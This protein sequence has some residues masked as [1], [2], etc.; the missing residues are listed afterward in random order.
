NH[1]TFDITHPYYMQLKAVHF[2]IPQGSQRL[3]G[4]LEVWQGYYQSARPTK[5][6]MQININFSA[7]AFYEGGDLIAIVVKFLNKKSPDD[8]RRG[9]DDRDR[10]KLG[11]FLRNLKVRV[12]H[13]GDAVA[14]R[15]YRIRGITPRPANQA[16]F[17]NSENE[18]V[19]VATYLH[20]TYNRPL[21]FPVS[22][23]CGTY[24]VIDND[25]IIR[26][27]HICEDT[28]G[29]HYQIHMYTTA[30]KIMQGFNQMTEVS[31]RVLPV[32]TVQ[33]HPS[34]LLSRIQPKE[35]AWNLRG[36]KVAMGT[37]LGSG[38]LVFAS[39]HVIS[40]EKVMHFLKKLI[41]TCQETGMN[42]PN[43]NPPINYANP[44]G[45]IEGS[46]KTAWFNARNRA[47]AQPKLIIYE[48]ETGG[49]NS[50]LN[51]THHA[52]G[53]TSITSLCASMDAKASRYAATIRPQMTRVG[54]SE[55]Q[56]KQVLCD[57]MTA[58]KTACQS[59]AACYCPPITFVVV[60]RR[61]HVRFF[62]IE[63]KDSDRSY[64]VTTIDD[65][66]THPFEFDFY[67]QSHPGLQG[68][69]RP[70]HYY[71][72]YDENRFTS[73]SACFHLRDQHFLDTESSEEGTG[74]SPTYVTVHPDLAK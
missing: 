66:I 12:V 35:D 1:G 5:G 70:T 65:N 59:M 19:D 41:T 32:P 50:F 60:Q 9:L 20:Q 42:I 28:N 31:A 6:R 10:V 8:L 63:K 34:Y 23:V 49:M 16:T 55:S 2:Y 4:G 43:R 27:N 14:M 46:L 51:V 48:C 25:D 74:I 21:R 36:V 17:T 38:V 58:I 11:M 67:L 56:F 71:V 69:S 61:H 44:Q 15:R 52:I 33:Y 73:D 18:V 26:N 37:T 40:E 30:N 13:C 24:L 68:T 47:K 7:T 3:F 53:R 57:E 62:P 29:R 39:N 54:V 22:F 64:R 45:D 72:L